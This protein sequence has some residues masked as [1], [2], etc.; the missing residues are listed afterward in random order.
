MQIGANDALWLPL[1][2]LDCLRAVYPQA[3]MQPALKAPG[4]AVCWQ[5]DDAVVEI[6]RARLTGFGPQPLAHIARSLSL[7]PSTIAQALARLEAQGYVL[8][9]RFTPGAAEE[10]WCERHL[11]ARIHRYTVRHLRREI[12]P[13]E[14][15]D[16]MRFLFEWQHVAPSARQ[17][18]RDALPQIIDQMEGFEAAAASWESEILPARLGDYSIDWLDELC[19]AGK[20]VWTRLAGPSRAAGGPVR[21]TPVVLLPRRHLNAWSALTDAAPPELSPRAEAVR[22]AL[23]RH[24]AMFFDELMDEARLL[25]TELENAL[26]ELVAVGLVNSDSFAGL[27]ALLMPAAKHAVRRRRPRGAIMGGMD[28][29]GRWA[30]VRRGPAQTP[31]QTPA[32]VGATRRPPPHDQQT[33]EHVAL[34]LL[35]RYGVVFWRLLDREADWLPAW[36]ELLPVYHRLEAR[37]E[38]RG[39]RFVSG[40]AGEQFAL[41]EA[42]P[43]LRNIRKQSANDTL[44]SIS[45]TDPLNLVGSL[46]PGDKVPAVAG[47]RVLY[48]DGVPVATLIANEF[49]WLTDTDT[50]AMP[51]LRA[52]L[53]GHG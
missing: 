49:H 27:R 10:E 20:V 53:A 24:G 52:A 41:P 19:R 26:K 23:L 51:N 2:R 1:E 11:L 46:L 6:V 36:R 17:S 42:V 50:Q 4:H 3:P 7:P 45:A 15:S 29:A 18:G 22:D 38:I 47:N 21:A 43:L 14:G 12:E 35:R 39:G 9:G 8:R 5:E 32:P 25:R 40:L 28:D 34:T 13:V 48:R 30:L 16:F 33:I 31:T 44:V 37:G